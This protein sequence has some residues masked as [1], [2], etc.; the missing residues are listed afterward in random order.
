MSGARA[1][2]PRSP[3]IDKSHTHM[4]N[5]LMRCG[6]ISL[7]LATTL[8]FAISCGS[9]PAQKDAAKSSDEP[10]DPNKISQDRY[11]SVREGVQH[12]IGD[13]NNVINRKDFNAWKAALS[14]EYIEETSSPENLERISE[15]PAMK[16]QKIILKNLEDYF[17]N[18]VV[19]S[20]ASVNVDNIDIEFIGQNRVKAFTVTT[21]RSG[22][23]QRVRLYD[24]E[25]SGNSWKIIN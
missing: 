9:P 18:V 21:T 24:L 13:L 4:Y 15:M 25:Q 23:E 5:I 10:F 7:L 11:I 1:N 8:I 22:E 17:I 16:T 19:P 14:A 12:F 3:T 2:T 20:R 6:K